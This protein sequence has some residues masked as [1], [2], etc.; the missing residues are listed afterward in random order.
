[1]AKSSSSSIAHYF[2]KLETAPSVLGK[3]TRFSAPDDASSVLAGCTV[4]MLGLSRAKAARVEAIVAALGGETTTV[5]SARW[6]AT[7]VVVDYWLPLSRPATNAIC[8]TLHWLE[9]VQKSQRRL[10]TSDSCFFAPPLPCARLLYPIDDSY[11]DC[12]DAAHLR[13]PSSPHHISDEGVPLWPYVAGLLAQPLTTIDALQNA[14][15]QIV[16]SSLA[17]RSLLGLYKAIQALPPHD[18]HVFLAQV[19][20]WMQTLALELPLLFLTSPPL[21][22]RGKSASVTL[23]KRQTACLLVH[24]F[25]CTHVP[26]VPKT[27]PHAINFWRL[28]AARSH[29]QHWRSS[30]PMVQKLVCLLHYFV[31]L[32][33]STSWTQCVTFGRT[34][35]DDPP[36]TST[37]CPWTSVVV[38]MNGAIE[39]DMG[40]VQID[41]ANK[42]AGGGVLGHGCVQEEIRFV[43]NPECIVACAL[44]EVLGDNERFYVVGTEQYARYRGYGA[45]FA[46]DGDF[47]DA[48]PVDAVT[49]CRDT[50]IVGIDATKYASHCVHHQYRVQDMRRELHKACVGFGALPDEPLTAPHRA[51]ATGNW[52]CGVFGGDVQL[53]F[54]LQWVAASLQG[55]STLRYYTFQ[56]AA[57]VNCLE[58][59]VQDVKTRYSVRDVLVFLAS[60][61]PVAGIDVFAALSRHTAVETRARGTLIDA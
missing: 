12:W 3:R 19:L 52:G 31:R 51:I 30:A 23:T 33:L 8:V 24:G 50:V 55:R 46:F 36:P 41:F 56:H 16:G 60:Y 18:A 35:D 13:L 49:K 40:A 14:I 22:R 53:K 7:Y 17:P 29:G 21:L 39:A 25:F 38:C 43:I 1:M 20:P 42:F 48:T 10:C 9:Q 32:Q 11:V 61:T 44:T 15:L 5:A 54:L 28:H 27:F 34:H 4:S 45:T 6:R 2:A 57:L 59:T 26:D 58:N 47:V 37:A